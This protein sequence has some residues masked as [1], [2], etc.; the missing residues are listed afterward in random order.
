MPLLQ[1]AIDEYEQADAWNR[2]V[3]ALANLTSEALFCMPAYLHWLITSIPDADAVSPDPVML[4]QLIG[5][6]ERSLSLLDRPSAVALPDVRRLR[7]EL[8]SLLD[9]WHKRVLTSAEQVKFPSGDAVPS[10]QSPGPGAAEM[11]LRLLGLPDLSRDLGV[12]AG[13]TRASSPHRDAM[14]RLRPA[15]R[16]Y[17]AAALLV[18]GDLPEHDKKASAFAAAARFDDKSAD[19]VELRKACARL[20]DAACDLLASLPDIIQR[21][22][23][24]NQ[25][26]TDPAKRARQIRNLRAARRLLY[27]VHPWDVER[28]DFTGP[29]QLLRRAELYDLLVWQ[30]QRVA[31]EIA[32]AQAADLPSLLDA[33]NSCG[34]AAAAIPWQPPITAILHPGLAIESPGQIDLANK[35]DHEFPVSVTNHHGRDV[36]VW[37]AVDYDARTMTLQ[38]RNQAI[39]YDADSVRRM[40]G[41]ATGPEGQQ[42]VETY[43]TNP[44]LDALRP[45]F[46]LQPGETKTLWVQLH[47]KTLA[48]SD[49]IISFHAISQADS[50]RHDLM[51]VLPHRLS[52]DLVAEGIADSWQSHDAVLTFYPYPNRATPYTLSLTNAGPVD[53]VVDLEILR[54]ES[55]VSV[56]SFGDVSRE[57]AQEYLARLGTLGRVLKVE[58]IA[59][60]AGGRRVPIPFAAPTEPPPKP[61]AA[62]ATTAAEAAPAAAAAEKKPLLASDLLA[63]ITDCATGRRAIKRIEILTQ[64]PARYVRPRVEYDAQRRRVDIV[65]QPIR[66]SVIPPEGV[67]IE[68]QPDEIGPVD[69]QHRSGAWLRPARPKLPSMWKC[70]EIPGR[71]FPSW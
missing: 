9:T 6:L 55:P 58:K 70:R 48:G 59:V 20:G 46:K 61:P 38:A 65:V 34:R 43:P 45:T 30:Q 41:L 11:R 15:A 56:P 42:S 32:D 50:V 8:E 68:G 22:S 40:P 37:L 39:L 14:D 24:E 3:V 57:A 4:E 7:H 29:G 51:A 60:A 28:M 44:K 26:L 18:L 66:P 27:L 63:V 64:R 35:L 10:P 53:R 36:D 47:R 33:A 19:A 16:L 25:D 69:L 2:D 67:W 54:S 52:V 71:Y 17:A 49:A 21:V 31:A 13:K 5:N 62:P 1:R 12:G 23:A